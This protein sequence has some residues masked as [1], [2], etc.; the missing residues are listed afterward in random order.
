MNEKNNTLTLEESMRKKNTDTA[1]KFIPIPEYEAVCFS[2]FRS[3]EIVINSP[4]DSVF[5]DSNIVFNFSAS[6][7]ETKYLKIFDNKD[8][9]LFTFP[10]R[11][12]KFIQKVSLPVGLF[13]WKVEN[14]LELLYLG[15]VSIKG[16]S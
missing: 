13:Y 12:R 14:D 7:G 1:D 16:K 9:M 15:K 4:K 3:G 8:K 10:I 5:T 11:E 2:E 6:G